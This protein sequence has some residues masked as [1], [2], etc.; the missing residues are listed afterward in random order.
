[1][2]FVPQ[3]PEVVALRWLSVGTENSVSGRALSVSGIVGMIVMMPQT[4][5]GTTADKSNVQKVILVI[6]LLL[7]EVL[8]LKHRRFRQLLLE[9]KTHIKSVIMTLH[10]PTCLYF[11]AYA[12]FIAVL[13]FTRLCIVRAVCRLF[14]ALFVSSI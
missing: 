8:L 6:L 13:L 12:M 14:H 4:R 9:K 5:T 1:M 11:I 7:F 3:P 2:C 10:Y